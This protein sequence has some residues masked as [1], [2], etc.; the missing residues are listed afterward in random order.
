MQEIRLVRVGDVDSE[1]LS[2]LLVALADTLKMPCSLEK[3]V[4]APALLI[5]QADS[6]IF[7]PNCWEKSGTAATVS[8]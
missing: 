3:K 5:M 1:I 6:N 8:R 7:P 4:I 2:W